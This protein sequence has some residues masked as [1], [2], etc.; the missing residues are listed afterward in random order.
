MQVIFAQNSAYVA[1]LISPDL[2]E[3]ANA[4]VRLSEV[5][6]TISS[7]RSLNIKHKRVVTILNEQGL[8]NIDA[9]EYY[10][11]NRKIKKIEAT[12]LDAL[13]KEIKSIKRRDFKDVSVGDGFSVFN[14]NRAVYLEYTPIQ[15]PFTVIFES[16]V[17]TS[18]T[19]F[20]Q[21]WSPI[22]G[23]FVSTEKSVVTIAFKQDLGFK[24]K[25]I[26]FLPKHNSIK[27][28]T[29][30]NFSLVAT[31]VKAM[32]YENSS[33]EFSKIAPIAY[34]KVEKFNLE[35]VDGEAKTWEEYGKWYYD[36]LIKGSE[37]LPLETKN[38]IIQLVG[39][40]KNT[41]QIAKLIY[42]YVQDK[43]R[44]VSIQVGIGGFKAMLA[45]DVDKLGYGDCKA[46]SNYTRALLD[47]VGV[48]SYNTL[49]YGGNYRKNI[50]NDF[51]SQQG[52]HMILS[53]PDGDNYIWLEC[54]SQTTPFA[55][56]GN[57]TDDRDV[58]IIKP[59]GGQI[60]KTK[61]YLEKDNSQSSIGNYV[62]AA[63]GNL[64]AKISIASKGSQYDDS[65]GRERFSADQ[66]DDFYKDYFDN[67]N[68]L[69]LEK[70]SFV[71]DR[72]NIQ[73]TQNVELS[74]TAYATSSSNK[75]MFVL[76]AFNNNSSTPK[77]YRNRENPF[78]V[79][80]G[81]HDYDEITVNLPS[82]FEIEALPQDYEI[83]NK[84][85]EYKTEIIKSNPT[86]LIYKRSLFIKNG[87]YESKD[88][89]EYRLFREQVSKND[90]AKIILNKKQ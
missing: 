16:E 27:T 41:L 36:N 19:A 67:I 68:A 13:G 44:Y 54:T 77:R 43:T 30:G 62:I 60:I 14:D 31:N 26:N 38:K 88:Y 89:D 51:V 40:E 65:Y 46:L 29:P 8:G 48:K 28:E 24:Y 69:K 83:K 23:Y 1:L 18:N 42:K 25:E 39:N 74:A 78:E 71:N 3:N 73:F 45:K 52:N 87:F 35:G 84:Y 70:I 34:F 9:R 55:Y 86:T 32:K 64:K 22:D 81:Y 12:I 11:P 90:N 72:E 61:S 59:E 47:I 37:E 15:Y 20:L 82:G 79:N 49:V 80:R 4:V 7:Q 50:Q 56:Q 5:N 66:K 58:L 17:E 10:D 21:P 76:N 63:D 85:G 2:K 33:P 75:L 6:Y 57:S 53:I